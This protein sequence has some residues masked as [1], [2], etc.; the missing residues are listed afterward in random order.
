MCQPGWGLGGNRGEGINVYVYTAESL[1]C[2][3]ETITALFIGYAL[4]QNVS[5]IKNILN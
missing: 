1:H 5:G 2:S 4:I 3:P